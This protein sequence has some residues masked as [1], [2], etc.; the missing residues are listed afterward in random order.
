MAF[1]Y[2]SRY[3][4]VVGGLSIEARG[5]SEA[6]VACQGLRD[7]NLCSGGAAATLKFFLPRSSIWISRRDIVR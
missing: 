1:A 3:T 6:V 7:T 5:L 2:Q 4:R